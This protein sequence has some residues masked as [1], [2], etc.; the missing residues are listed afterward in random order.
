MPATG[1]TVRI[2][3]SPVVSMQ[4]A[5]PNGRITMR[6]NH[7]RQPK[8]KTAAEAYRRSSNGQVLWAIIALAIVIGIIVHAI[9]G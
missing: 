4:L 2:A 8:P 3:V 6:Y 1:L 5:V 9:H 7:E